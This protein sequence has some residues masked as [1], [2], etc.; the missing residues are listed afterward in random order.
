MKALR[1]AGVMI[2]V[3]AC[4]GDDD[5]SS[6]A[7]VCN[8]GEPGS[9]QVTCLDKSLDDCFV[10]IDE[11]LDGYN[12]R[13]IPEGSSSTFEEQLCGQHVVRS[14]RYMG[15]YD[16]PDVTGYEVVNVS[17]GQTTYISF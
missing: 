6:G 15:Y 8:D 14:I 2:F 12:G 4:G 7:I 13:Y 9:I 17:S 11:E 5:G 3:L 10:A 1:I 16:L